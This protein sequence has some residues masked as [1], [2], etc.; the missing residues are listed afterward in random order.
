[1]WIE[2]E[3]EDRRRGCD[4]IRRADP[5]LDHLAPAALEPDEHEQDDEREAERADYREQ[6]L[7]RLAV[8]MGPDQHAV[9]EE[10]ERDACRRDLRQRDAEEDHPAQDEIDAD[11]RTHDADEH[12]GHERVA[13]Q[14]VG[15]ED[16]E[17]RAQAES[18]RPPA[19]SVTGPSHGKSWSG[20]FTAR[21][22]STQIA[23]CT[24]DRRRGR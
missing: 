12:A 7:R 23:V 24:S 8:L 21:P 3:E 14:E 5:R 13:E 11:E 1:M 16:L 20:A 18:V 19:S 9:R 10:G 6:L 17:Q 2:G 22:P 15:A 4:G